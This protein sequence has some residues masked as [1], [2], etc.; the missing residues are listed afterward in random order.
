MPTALGASLVFK[1]HF[2]SSIP[3]FTSL[4]N[5]ISSFRYEGAFDEDEKHGQGIET[6]S[7]GL[8]GLRYFSPFKDSSPP[9]HLSANLISS[10][11]YEGAFELLIYSYT[12][13]ISSFRYV[14]AFKNGEWH[15]QG[16]QTSANGY[17]F[18]SPFKDW[19]ISSLPP[20]LRH[21]FLLLDTRELS[22]KARSMAK[23]LRRI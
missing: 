13:L 21:K 6:F 9:I 2:F 19:L 10:F 14:G 22:K 12:Y 5:L 7:D 8:L 3:L 23:E 16:V 15:G 1:T 17:R 4:V 20:L 11:R 18:F